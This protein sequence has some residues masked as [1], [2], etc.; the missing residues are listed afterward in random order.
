MTEV[1]AFAGVTFRQLNLIFTKCTSHS[2]AVYWRQMRLEKARRLMDS[3]ESLK[4]G[5]G[6]ERDLIE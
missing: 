2:A 6:V 3:I 1:A 4:S 5:D